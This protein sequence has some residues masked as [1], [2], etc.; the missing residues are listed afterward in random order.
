MSNAEIGSCLILNRFFSRA[1]FRKVINEEDLDS[2]FK[3]TIERFVENADLKTNGEAIR[4]IYCFMSRF[5]RNEYFYI[6]TL[7]NKLA[8]G[9]YSL[10]TTR[11]LTQVPIGKSKADLILLNDQAVVYEIKTDLDSFDRL[12]TQVADYYK[13]FDRVCVVTSV[14]RYE[15]AEQILRD[16]PVGIYALNSDDRISMKFRKKPERYAGGLKHEVLFKLLHKVEFESI[17]FDVY[18]RLPE[19]A[20]VFYYDACFELCRGIPIEEMHK[21]VMDQLKKRNSLATKR[22]I[23]VPYELRALFYFLKISDQQVIKLKGFLESKYWR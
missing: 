5:Y 20:P 18:G 6:N 10:R 23:D 17:L 21:R 12:K 8:M 4:D 15:R 2:T 19:V 1:V 11:V 14:D 22:F 13:A 3:A 16:S 9:K 7:F